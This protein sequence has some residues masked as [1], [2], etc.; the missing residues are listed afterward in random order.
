MRSLRSCENSRFRTSG[1][2]LVELMIM[3]SIVAL[4]GMSA[5]DVLLICERVSAVSRLYTNARV[6]V[7]R[8][9]DNATGVLFTGTGTSVAPVV[10]QITSSSGV[11]C[12]DDAGSPLENISVLLSGTGN[13]LVSGTLSRK[14]TILP[15]SSFASDVVTAGVPPV[16]MQVQFQID[17]DY[18][19]RHYTFSETTLRSQDTQ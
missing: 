15:A 12:D 11:V 6:V 14:V 8:N 4:I 16:V 1:V 19:S 17:Y 2:T 3:L 18:R 13:I 7:Q 10:L 5:M 9:L